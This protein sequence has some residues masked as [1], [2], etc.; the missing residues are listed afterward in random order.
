MFRNCLQLCNF[1]R[2]SFIFPQLCLSS[3][4]LSLY[5]YIYIYVCVCVCAYELY[6][7]IWHIHYIACCTDSLLLFVCFLLLLYKVKFTL[8]P[9]VITTW[10]LSLESKYILSDESSSSWVD[11]YVNWCKRDTLGVYVDIW[12]LLV[13]FQFPSHPV[14]PD[15]MHW[16][17]EVWISATT[18]MILEDIRVC[19][20]RSQ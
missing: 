8:R 12:W 10:K 5:I 16:A 2:V 9:R 7:H 11:S 13:N 17:V 6:N 4:S 14:V 19:C 15:Y 3:L 1:R 20:V 18:D